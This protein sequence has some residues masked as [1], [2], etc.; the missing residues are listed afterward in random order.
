MRAA[1]VAAF[2]GIALTTTGGNAVAHA[3]L[4]SSDPEANATLDRAPATISLTFTETP[5]PTF[6]S[7]EVLDGTGNPVPVAPAEDRPSIAQHHLGVLPSE[8]PD[9]TYTVSWRVVSEEDGHSTVGAFSFGVGVAPSPPTVRPQTPGTPGRLPVA[10]AGKVLLYAGLAI[11]VAATVVGLWAL[12]GAVPA[13][14]AVLIGAGAAALI[15]A[16][17]LFIAESDTLDVSVRDL[18]GSRVGE[19]FVRLVVGAAV[20]AALALVAALVPGWKTLALA[21]AGAAAAMLIRA[22]GGH[23]AAAPTAAWLQVGLQ[24]FH[25][26]AMS[27]WIGGLA[28]VWG[29]LRSRRDTDPPV[30]EVRRY[31]R[32]AG[33][34]LAVVVATGAIRAASELGGVGWWLRAFD[35]SYGTTLAVKIAI[36]VGLIGLG[37]WNR[38]RSIPRLDDR[39]GMLRR[40][41]AIE[42]VGAV[43]VFGLTGV[44]TS[45]PPDPAAASAPAPAPRVVVEG[46]DFATTMRVRVIVTPGMPG[47]N[48]FDV[49]ILD[50]DTGEPLHADRV[51]LRFDAVSRSEIGV[52]TLRLDAG[53]GWVARGRCVSLGPRGLGAHGVDPAGSGGNRDPV[54][55]GGR[56]PGP[57]RRCLDR[58][59][60][61]RDPHDH[62]SV[63]G[64]GCRSIWTPTCP[65]RARCTSRRSMRRATSSRSGTWGSWRSRPMA[66]RS[67]W[68][69]SASPP[70]TSSRRSTCPRVSGPSCSWRRPATPGR[71]RRRS[72]RRFERRV[73]PR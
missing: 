24:W 7:I 19:L 29:F 23:A 33:Y 48:R 34:A 70:A 57:D 1:I 52:S 5:D 18:A 50:F 73:A 68:S 3:N 44:L 38:Y 69:R 62:R 22:G 28:L 67:S 17:L 42:L 11:L 49:R 59:G 30:D 58:A 26:L 35:T 40:V 60:A 21:G 63:R 72:S 32:M 8:V 15:G 13:R 65:A 66:P 61:T 47:A 2:A 37:A 46:S 71:S 45:L 4:E 20:A 31:S 6:S 10:V 36:V 27:V 56:E 25:L 41:M 53:R 16:V 9:G 39:P 14:R 12:A 64:L 51:A 43:G 55:G 54:G